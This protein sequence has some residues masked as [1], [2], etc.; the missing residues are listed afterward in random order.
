MSSTTNA[1]VPTSAAPK[2]GT[3]AVAA[4][5]KERSAAAPPAA[6]AKYVPTPSDAE[7]ARGL[8][9]LSENLFRRVITFV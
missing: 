5:L 3:G 4:A 9:T 2:E 8:T 7:F 1:S 6:V